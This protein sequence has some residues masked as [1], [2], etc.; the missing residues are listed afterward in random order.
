MD[1]AFPHP[2]RTQVYTK[3]E[4]KKRVWGKPIQTVP[5]LLTTKG[6]QKHPETTSANTSSKTVAIQ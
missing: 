5:T 2:Y 4:V 1:Q 6:P 3:V